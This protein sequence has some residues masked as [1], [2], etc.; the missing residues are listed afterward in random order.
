MSAGHGADERPHGY[1]R[2]KLD[3]CRCYTCGWAVA[4][5]NDARDHAIRRGTW[6]PYTDT[7]PV[8]AH[9]AALQACGMGLRRIADLAHCDRKRLQAITTGRP[10]RG[11]G[12]Q[13]QVRPALAAAVL[14][15][16]PTLDNLAAATVIDATGTRR[17]LHALVAGGWPQARLAAGLGMA[18]GNFGLTLAAPRV[19]VRTARAVHDLYD[20]WWN[21]N[22]IE[23]G[24]SP[25][26]VTRA[27]RHAVA[28]GWAPAGAWDDDTIG[29]PIAFPDWTGRCGTPEGYDAHYR[30][31]VPACEPC[32][33][34]KA[35]QR[36]ERKDARTAGGAA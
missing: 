32:R 7:D 28:R 6:Q 17:R 12:P 22:P 35:A 2:Y 11:T 5:Y 36:R 33:E 18:P 24:A 1:A 21:A 16:E 13:P 9:I 4:Q 26:G 19:R 31:R 10:E 29:D 14:A 23:H 34:A 15:I 3:G 8:R 20:R 27:R 25:G 30:F